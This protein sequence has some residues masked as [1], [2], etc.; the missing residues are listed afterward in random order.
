MW[1]KYL[2]ISVILLIC[3]V[4]CKKDDMSSLNS[5]ATF[6]DYRQE[7]LPDFSFAGYMHNEVPI[8]FVEQKIVIT[9]QAGMDRANI[10]AAVDQLAA[11]PLV[12]GF[13]GAVLLKAGTYQVDNT[14]FINASG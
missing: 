1:R 11:L 10:Q 4:A 2:S 8:P 9:P 5:S 14:I 13:R 6:I 7:N 3:L 12:N